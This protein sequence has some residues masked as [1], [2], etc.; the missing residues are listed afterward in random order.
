MFFLS[1]LAPF[2]GSSDFYCCLLSKDSV[3]Y[4][5]YPKKTLRSLKIFS[6]LRTTIEIKLEK[7][8]LNNNAWSLVMRET[9]VLKIYD[10]I[11]W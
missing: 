4:L 10:K 5:E 8:P 3:N 9:K 6:Q 1:G 11:E 7:T 2:D